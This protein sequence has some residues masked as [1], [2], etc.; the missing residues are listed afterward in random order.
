MPIDMLSYLKE[1]DAGWFE[2]I[3]DSL[4]NSFLDWLLPLVSNAGNGGMIWIVLGLVFFALGRV[5]TK[6]TAV[7]M[8]MALFVSFLAGEEGLKQLFQRPRP[9]ETVPGVQL[10]VL[11]PQSFS[12]PSGHAANAFASCLILARR[13]PALAWPAYGL[14]VTMALSRVYVGVHYPLDILAGSLLG[15]ACAL[16]VLKYEEAVFRLAEKVKAGL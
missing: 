15:I 8:V 9:F 5:E 6:K 4:H 16:L 11:P 3:N 13:I 14:A 7:L 12:F 10:L 2:R 1:L